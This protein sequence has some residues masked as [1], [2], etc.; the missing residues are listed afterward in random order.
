MDIWNF[1]NNSWFIGIV[2]GILS[3]LAT[4]W[5][6]RKLFSEKDKKEYIRKVDSTN[7]EIVYSLRS[8][9]SDNIHHDN[10]IITSLMAATAR[11]NGVLITDIYSIKE[12]TED[13]IKEVMDSSFIPSEYKNKY[14]EGLTK[15]YLTEEV[16]DQKKTNQQ[17]LRKANL[18]YSER[19][20]SI[21]STTTALLGVT[22]TMLTILLT[23]IQ[24]KLT[25]LGNIDNIILPKLLRP[26]GISFLLVVPII[27]ATSAMMLVYLRKLIYIK[28]LDKERKR[29]SLSSSD[30]FMST[31]F[32]NELKKYKK[33]Q[34]K[35]DKENEKP[36]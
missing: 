21:I 10:K 9:I 36:E 4:T 8:A 20:D 30:E 12:V 3:G 14:C 5:L 33:Q 26:D 24:R 18:Y 23:F 32:Y 29:Q 34:E 17:E 27:A 16:T 35:T 25:I 13:L 11:K 6:G 31:R 28:Q 2:G 19:K 22:V 1:I 7:K 15:T